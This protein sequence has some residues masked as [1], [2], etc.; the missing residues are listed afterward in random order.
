MAFLLAVAT[1]GK[2]A[3]SSN[4]PRPEGRSYWMASDR[5]AHGVDSG[6]G[7]AAR[8]LRKGSPTKE[9]VRRCTPVSDRSAALGGRGSKADGHHSQLPAYREKA[10]N[11]RSPDDVRA[12][13]S[14]PQASVETA[15]KLLAAWRGVVESL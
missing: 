3:G 12:N 15:A 6:A 14:G 1:A 10:V 8:A 9:G 11:G 7:E 5:E 13:A 4:R 2:R